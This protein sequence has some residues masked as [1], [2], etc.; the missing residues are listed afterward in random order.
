MNCA[1]NNSAIEAATASW[2]FAED[3]A[4][5]FAHIDVK[6]GNH[7]ALEARISSRIGVR[8]GGYQV[9]YSEDLHRRMSFI[10]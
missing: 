5:Y 3:A 4:S 10:L 6:I 2:V 9:D 8:G 7:R 1:S